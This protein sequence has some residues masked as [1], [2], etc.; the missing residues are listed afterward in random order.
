MT[1]ETAIQTGLKS[2]FTG[3]SNLTGISAPV[4]PHIAPQGSA[5]PFVIYTII[6]SSIEKS[7]NPASDTLTLT[8]INIELG[9]FSTSMET[10]SLLMA[11]I[12]DKLHG[13]RGSLGTESLDIRESFLESA[14]TFSESEL[15]GS[16]EQIYRASLTFNLYY[17]WS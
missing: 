16:D 4:Y 10:R 17:N 5:Y 6:N 3:D 1:I 7:I 13:F 11:S 8:N 15:T 9:I 12:K 14:A 2:H